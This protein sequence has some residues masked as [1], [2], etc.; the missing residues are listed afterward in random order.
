MDEIFSSNVF[1]LGTDVHYAVGLQRFPSAVLKTDDRVSKKILSEETISAS[2]S[3]EYF[4][5]QDTDTDSLISSN[6]K[7]SE[8]G[9]S[10]RTT[11]E[12]FQQHRLES[13]F[14]MI[15]LVAT[16]ISR[17]SDEEQGFLEPEQEQLL[18]SEENELCCLPLHSSTSPAPLPPPPPLLPP[19]LLSQFPSPQ[20]KS[21]FLPSFPL[22]EAWPP[23]SIE[24]FHKWP[25]FLSLALPAALSLFLEWG[26]YE[27]MA[28]FAGQLGSI[29]LATHGV[30]MNTASLAYNGPLAIADATSVLAGNY[31]GNNQPSDASSM[32]L[33]GVVIDSFL[34]LITGSILLFFLRSSWGSIFTSDAD[35][36][37]AVHRYMP[38]LFLYMFVDSVKCVTCNVLRS[39]GRPTVTTSGNLFCC[40]FVLIPTGWY[41]ALRRGWGLIGLWG[42]M[43]IG[44]G[45]AALIYSVVL[46]QTDWKQQAA[47]AYERNR[48]SSNK[49]TDSQHLASGGDCHS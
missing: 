11:K 2:L 12:L 41:L 45:V 17:K 36:I 46:Y 33:I 31:L 8:E 35:V 37:E 25:I 14:P 32:V 3:A 13:E 27:V 6:L 30:Y 15:E 40:L 18:M 24:V 28:G 20:S 1:D 9:D 34:G 21:S 49:C 39:T 42:G 22:Q 10:P 47:E 7:S 23:W 44:W 5:E 16:K 26:S 48:D 29:Q 19:L 43:S 4:D 38:I